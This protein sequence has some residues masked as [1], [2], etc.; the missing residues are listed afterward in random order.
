[1]NDN[2]FKGIGSYWTQFFQDR[3]IL[4]S[5]G[6]ASTEMLSS[7]YMELSNLVLSLSHED[8]PV[9][10]RFKWDT[11]ILK[12]LDVEIVNSKY[13]F[14]LSP[15]FNT[16]GLNRSHVI[17]SSVVSPKAILNQ[18]YDFFVSDGFIDFTTD[19]F[20]ISG[21]PIREVDGDLQITLWCPIADIDTNRIW[22]NYGHFIKRWRFSTPAYK[23]FVRGMFHTRMFGP[24]VNRIESG[25][26]LIAGL[27]VADGR[28]ETVLAVVKLDTQWVVKT[29]VRDYYITPNV[30]I[31]VDAGDVL[32]PFQSLTDTVEV[33]D[34]LIEPEWWKGNVNS[35]PPVIGETTDVNKA[36]DQ[37]LKYNTFLVRINLTPFLRDISGL[38]PGNLFDVNSFIE[39]L[40]EF[41]PS[42]TY[43][44]PLFFLRLREEIPPA[45][46]VDISRELYSLEDRHFGY[47][48]YYTMSSGLDMS[49]EETL[50]S[51]GVEQ[52][53]SN[54]IP[55]NTMLGYL[56][57]PYRQIPFIP[58]TLSE[59]INLSSGLDM[60][61]GAV[62][63]DV[64]TY[65]K[66][67]SPVEKTPL[68]M[69]DGVTMSDGRN[70]Q[71]RHYEY[72]YYDMSMGKNIDDA[73][74]TE[75]FAKQGYVEEVGTSRSV[76]ISDE[77]DITTKI[78]ILSSGSKR[79]DDLRFGP[80]DMSDG[81]D[82]S[83][84]IHMGSNKSDEK[85]NTE[86][87][88]LSQES[89]VEDTGSIERAAFNMSSGFNMSNS[90]T[91]SS[92]NERIQRYY[93]MDDGAT[94][95]DGLDCSSLM[96]LRLAVEPSVDA[97]TSHLEDV[98]TEDNLGISAEISA[99]KEYLTFGIFTMS[100]GYNM[101]DGIRMGA[102]RS[103]ERYN[104]IRVAQA[105][106]RL[107]QEMEE[108]LK[109]PINLSDGYDM[110]SGLGANGWIR[111]NSPYDFSDSM[112]MADG[113]SMDS[114]KPFRMIEEAGNYEIASG[115][116]VDNAIPSGVYG[117]YTMSVIFDMSA[118][119]NMSDGINKVFTLPSIPY[120]NSLELYQGDRLL[121]P[122]EDY[123]LSG[124]IIT[125]TVGPVIS[126]Y[127]VFYRK[128]DSS[129]A[130]FADHEIPVGNVD[131]INS[132]FVISSSVV[133]E[134]SLR[135]HI[136][137]KLSVGGYRFA[138]PYINFFNPPAPGSDIRV[139]YRKYSRIRFV[140]REMLVGDVDGMNTE[141]AL[142]GIPDGGQIKL[143]EGG[144]WKASGIDY[145]LAGSVVSFAIAPLSTQESYYRLAN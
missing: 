58:Y 18:G 42:Y 135:V 10:D 129:S 31:R 110:S 138:A 52:G 86:R 109:R 98:E 82:M 97:Q 34:W 132:Q 59:D 79:I 89:L 80:Y 92:G 15:A 14:P 12:S 122:S 54:V 23:N 87:M 117:Y 55:W 101:S 112:T 69:S 50:E 91:M 126:D 17:L 136:N 107:D 131:G 62:M 93:I 28:N 46:Y 128:D 134:D 25:L 133:E 4:E 141:F 35:L 11:L 51:I 57:E 99:A 44:F 120:N 13:R 116:F 60:S 108:A 88:L 22:K 104:H 45:V 137:G 48:A 94:T 43:V 40:L 32:T 29:T 115:L 26:Q 95:N 66:W 84:G 139:F 111:A 41:K 140:D 76:H 75:R 113:L 72:R 8:V 96:R 64:V 61:S 71:S 7:V 85:F 142:S 78:D 106:E 70:M 39:F 19:P 81:Y 37:Y 143:F 56:P 100:D 24:I 3:S 102:N 9:Y 1:M 144:E 63:G 83:G 77:I 36:F 127:K 114:F 90:V 130:I 123:I 38:T 47:P 121:I 124:N 118:G 6:A 74:T 105:L 53:V 5:F 119:I 67:V 20:S 65:A 103:D 27:P 21:I 30:N 125:F 2:F 33:V 16:K 73:I 68:T 49:D 145:T